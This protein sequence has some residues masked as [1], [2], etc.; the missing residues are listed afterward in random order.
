LGAP[1]Q[2]PY[3]GRAY[4]ECTTWLQQRLAQITTER[5]ALVI[6]GLARH[7]GSDVGFSVYD[8]TWLDGLAA[9]VHAIRAAGVP[10]LVM[11]PT[12]KP[13]ADV[14]S[15]LAAHLNNVSAC[16]FPRAVA[17]NA[18]GQTAEKHAVITAG[19]GYLDVTPLDL[20]NPNLLSPRRQPARLP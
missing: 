9:T 6:L 11:G 1:V 10:V 12:P 13:P 8:H 19:G 18:A 16:D 2:S 7:Y 3:L 15:C 5:P 4:T 17:V 14:P 20:H